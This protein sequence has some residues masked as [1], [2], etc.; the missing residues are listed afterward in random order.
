MG[1][2]LRWHNLTAVMRRIATIVFSTDL[3]LAFLSLDL[4]GIYTLG[5]QEWRT[6][7]TNG[8]LSAM[9]W[10]A[11]Y[12]GPVLALVSILLSF[13]SLNAALLIWL[14]LPIRAIVA[15]KGEV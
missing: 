15:R 9:P 6:D 10:W 7:E 8:A 5:K 1:T 13:V 3:G 14:L 11:V 4:L 2:M 12:A